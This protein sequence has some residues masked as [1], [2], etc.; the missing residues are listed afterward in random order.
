MTG[1]ATNTDLGSLAEWLK[2]QRAVVLLTHAKPDGD[3][4]GST[5][6]LARTLNLL[7][8]SSGAA[9][10]AEC[11]Y[12]GPTPEW[13]RSVWGGSKVRVVEAGQPVPGA[14]DPS[15]VVV[16][17]TGTW[18]QLDPFVDWLR[19]RR[20]HTAVI[21]HHLHG[22]AEVGD[23]RIVETEAAAVCQPVAR[24]CAELLGVGSPA[25]LPVE[26]AE[27]LYMGLAT[28]TGWFRHSN[29]SAAVM[30]MAGDLLEAGV[31]HARL[32]EL[33][34]MQE[35][36]SRLR[37]MARA[38]A[39]LE[40]HP[41]KQAAFMTLTHQDFLDCGAAPGESGGFVDLPQSVA[42]VRV[43]AVLTEAE[44][45]HPDGPL[46]KVSMRSKAETHDGKEPVDVA[47]VCRA[48]GGGGHARAAGVRLRMTLEQAKAALLG[49]LP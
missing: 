22:D 17:D 9:S 32:Y 18:N 16:T 36:P 31:N 39:S 37:L 8:G 14:L 29:V 27:P 47:A 34:Q 46:A 38:L 11:W 33:I 24:L 10:V 42:S 48:L 3:A 7:R 23:R 5:L 35:R 49:A 4:L 28:D 19:P 20:E 45:G 21:D 1:W 43:A 2:G 25:R 30:R 44:V 26:V 12:G 15:A 6:A 13:A 41:E 40:L